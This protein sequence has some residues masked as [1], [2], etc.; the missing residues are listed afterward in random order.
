VCAFCIWHTNH[1]TAVLKIIFILFIFILW[2]F[3]VVESLAFNRRRKAEAWLCSEPETPPCGWQRAVDLYVS[4]KWNP[5]RT[6][7]WVDSVLPHVGRG[8]PQGPCLPT[9]PNNVPH[10]SNE[11]R[12]REREILREILC[13]R[14]EV[15]WNYTVQALRQCSSRH[16]SRRRKPGVAHV[17]VCCTQSCR[18]VY[19]YEGTAAAADNWCHV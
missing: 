16:L 1:H 6:F 7:P 14:T 9:V 8:G 13:C 19:G 11:E 17:L 15:R 10:M 5:S 4:G 2:C 12:E 18:Q 3:L